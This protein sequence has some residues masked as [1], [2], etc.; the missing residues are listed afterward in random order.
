LIS[1]TIGAGAVGH[2]H[3]GND[4][5]SIFEIQ[6]LIESAWD[7]G[8]NSNGRLET[9]GIRGTRKYIGTPEV[10]NNASRNLRDSYPSSRLLL[11]VQLGT[12]AVSKSGYA[13]STPSAEDA[14]LCTHDRIRCSVEAFRPVE[15][16]RAWENMMLT[17]DEYFARGCA[18]NLS[19]KVRHTQ[20]P[21]VYLQHQGKHVNL[22]CTFPKQQLIVST[23]P[24]LHSCGVWKEPRRSIISLCV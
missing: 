6:D 22:E 24:F 12:G 13:V 18:T 23:R 20:L 19:G 5:P 4:I 10:T 16:G 9:G 2:E 17:I 15:N 14:G 21:P 1:Y 3:F 8:H 11:M 7:L